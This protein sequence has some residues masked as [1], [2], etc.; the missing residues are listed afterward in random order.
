M[1]LRLPASVAPNDLDLVDD[2]KSPGHVRFLVADTGVGRDEPGERKQHTRGERL[3]T[4]I[5][6]TIVHELE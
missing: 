3:A 1:R 6:S 2:A 4:D 5:G